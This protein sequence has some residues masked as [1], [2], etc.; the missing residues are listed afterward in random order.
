MY[1]VSAISDK[2][3]LV[4]G[5]AL[6]DSIRE[7]TREDFTIHYLTLD[8]ETKDFLKDI[9]NIKIYSIEDIEKDE[10]FDALK[11]N[12]PPKS[13][14]PKDEA[15]YHWALASFFTHYLIDKQNI[16]HCL[17][18]DTDICFYDDIKTIFDSVKGF[19][20][21]LITHKHIPLDYNQSVGYYNV[22]IVY[23]NN[24]QQSK[25]CLE[26][27]RNCVADKNNPYF[28]K[29]G[30]CGDQKYLELLEHIKGGVRIKTI[31]KDI[32]HAAPWNFSLSGVEDGM[33]TWDMGPAFFDCHVTGEHEITQ[34]LCFVHFSH[35]RPDYD[36]DSYKIDFEN[37]WG[38]ILPQKGVQEIYD[39]YFE[40]C[41]NTKNKYGI[42]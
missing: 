23:F 15:E 26:F 19:D 36:N 17:Y 25:K 9:E 30:S 41:K 7:N 16:E 29:F 14:D 18:S 3:Y 21:G 28:T 27:W 5:L 37:E 6:R 32:G 2:N 42:K 24:S 34:K 39:N 22:G 4:Y 1:H 31:D 11:K 40:L 35:F 8:E 10:W 12:N 20:V 38:N 13:G 33:L